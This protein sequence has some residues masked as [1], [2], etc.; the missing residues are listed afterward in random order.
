MATLKHELGARN[1]EYTAALAIAWVAHLKQKANNAPIV[2]S[3]FA[4]CG[5]SSLGYSMAGFREALAVEWDARAITTFKANFPSVPIWEG[6][7]HNLS[8]TKFLSLCK[9]A[10][11]ELDILDGSPPCQGFSTAGKREFFDPRNQLYNEFVRLLEGV[12]PKAFVMENVSGMVKG[13]MKVAFADATRKLRAAGYLVSV[14]LLDAQ[15]LGVP[16]SRKRLIWIGVRNDLDIG[17]QHPKPFG[18]PFSL[19]DAIWDLLPGVA[20]QVAPFERADHVAASRN[21]IHENDW[22]PSGEPSPT[23]TSNRPPVVRVLAQGGGYM[24]D[25]EWDGRDPRAAGLTTRPPSLVLQPKMPQHRGKDWAE[26]GRLPSE[27]SYAIPASAATGLRTH[28]GLGYD[29]IERDARK[30]GYSI[31]ANSVSELRS[32]TEAREMTPQECARVQ[33]FPDGF[34]FPENKTAAYRQIGNS[35]PPLMAREIALVIKDILRGR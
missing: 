3:T 2:V 31:R 19:A 27:P 22:I 20:G 26:K 12:R 29:N 18:P 14:R 8:A 32:D 24:K 21:M 35:V 15:W 6:D 28:R 11:G 5:G 9:L 30:P 33:S 34:I 4:G 10:K 16:Q 1:K 23:V 7:I 13:K 17:P 25:V